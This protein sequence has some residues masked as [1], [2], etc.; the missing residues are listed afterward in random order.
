MKSFCKNKKINNL[1]LNKRIFKKG[2][3]LKTNKVRLGKTKMRKENIQRFKNW[4][5][6]K[7]SV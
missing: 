3:I 4:P 5:K 1:K 7:K 2:K 6:K